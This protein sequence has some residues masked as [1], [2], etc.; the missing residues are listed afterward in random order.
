MLELY[1]TKRIENNT[2]INKADGVSLLSSFHFFF[3]CVSEYMQ[4]CG[5]NHIIS[6]VMV[7]KPLPR[8]KGI[9]G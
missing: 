2:T 9:S 7:E 1:P 4:L 3:I 6:T 5:Q 8:W